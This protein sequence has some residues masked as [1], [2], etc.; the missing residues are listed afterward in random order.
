MLKWTLEAKGLAQNVYDLNEIM[1]RFPGVDLIDRVRPWQV[2]MWGV[3]GKRT[4][5]Q[6]AM[7]VA[8]AMVN[9]RRPS[10]QQTAGHHRAR[11]TEGARPHQGEQRVARVVA[12]CA[13]DRSNACAAARYGLRRAG[14][15]RDRRAEEK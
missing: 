10:S 15:S 14:R 5:F 6:V 8:N 13:V 7:D 12:R 4:K 9:L 11:D 3:D 1:K 2:K